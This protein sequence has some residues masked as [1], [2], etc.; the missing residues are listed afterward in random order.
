VKRAQALKSWRSAIRLKHS[1]AADEE[2]ARKLPQVEEAIDR[3]LMT[4]EPLALDVATA[5]KENV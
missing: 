5:F 3:A 4:G 1:L 2:I